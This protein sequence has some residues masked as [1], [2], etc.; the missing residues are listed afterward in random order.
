[1]A[2]AI[3]VLVVVPPEMS[4]G[5]ADETT[6]AEYHHDLAERPAE[7]GADCTPD[8]ILRFA[9][10]MRGAGPYWNAEFASGEFEIETE[11]IIGR[12]D[13]PPLAEAVEFARQQDRAE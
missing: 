3:R 13:S 11:E 5:M 4:G 9:G 7:F 2:K 6:W 12:A 10:I 8:V 1:M